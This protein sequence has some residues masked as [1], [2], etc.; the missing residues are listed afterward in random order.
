MTIVLRP[1]ARRPPRDR[2][3][4]RGGPDAALRRRGRS[5]S[6]PSTSSTARSA[7]ILFN[8][9]PTSGHPGGSISSGRFVAASC[10]TPLD[11]DLDDP[12][13]QDADIVSYA[14]GHKAMGLYAMWAL[15][16]EVARVAA[17]E[18][19]PADDAPPAAPRGPARLPPQPHHR[20]PA[21]P[22]LRRQGARRAPDAG[23]AVREAVHRR[24]GRGRRQLHRP[25]LRGAR[26]LRRR[27]AA[28]ARRR[29]RG[30]AHARPRGRGAGR[31]RHRLAG[32]RRRAPRLEPGVHRQ[33]TAS[34]ARATLPGDYVQWTPAEL[35][36]LHDWNVV[37][38][39]DG[40][41]LQQVVAAQRRAA[42]LDNGQPTAIV[43]R[44]LKGW[45][46]GVEGKASH[47]AG[48]KLCSPGF[49][50]ALAE[51]TGGDDAAPADLR[52]R[53]PALR[54]DR[55]RRRAR[56][57]LLGR[58]ARSCARGW[59]RRATSTAALAARLQAAGERLDARAP[60]ARA[61]ARPASRPSTRSAAR[62]QASIPDELR[63]APGSS[64]TLRGALGDA[65]RS[66]QQGL[67]RRPAHG[68]GRPVRAPPA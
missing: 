31:G 19:L 2:R 9:V 59:S 36:Y 44:T 51:L 28:R 38:V 46:Y 33:R 12:D 45:R 13:R 58:A 23:H 68:L 32:Q 29:G 66:P 57:V 54:R 39:A 43:Y 10:S 25:R 8:Y 42:A 49:Y 55:R 30:R 17:P 61:R 18:L 11:Y 4:P 62:S 67:R 41:D 56:G 35:F 20:H 14:A 60:R 5:S 63:L 1:Q 7:R 40:R 65:L 64:T 24:L 22:A 27:R 3:R 53:R 26:P 15:R 47:G 52:R 50:E 37:E 48:H 16:D 34:A 6:R 21:L